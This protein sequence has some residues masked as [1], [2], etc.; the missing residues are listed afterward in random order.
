MLLLFTTISCPGS[1][2][3]TQKE[4]EK[5]F[6]KGLPHNPLFYLWLLGQRNP[7]EDPDC[8]GDA[9][10]TLFGLNNDRTKYSK[11]EENQ[12]IIK[13]GTTTLFYESAKKT[14]ITISLIQVTQAD[15]NILKDCSKPGNIVVSYCNGVYREVNFNIYVGLN[16]VTQFYAKSNVKNFIGA[17]RNTLDCN[18]IYKIKSEVLP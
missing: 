16:Q 6:I 10:G 15:P 11:L 13:N 12:E 7:K 18:V 3:S 4:A 17:G 9:I 8:G 2:E 14:L 1:N 5:E